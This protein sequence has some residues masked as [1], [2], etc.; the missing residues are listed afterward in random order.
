MAQ[1]T[2]LNLNGVMGPLRTFAAKT[3][4]TASG[5]LFVAAIG[6]FVPGPVATDVYQS[7]AAKADTFTPGAAAAD[8]AS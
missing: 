3:A 8:I 6:I 5:A 7:G 1:K 2:T 4:A